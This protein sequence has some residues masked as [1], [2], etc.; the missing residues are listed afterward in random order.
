MNQHLLNCIGVGHSRL[1]EICRL[2]ETFGFA[3]KLTGAGGGGCAIILLDPDASD[4]AIK[5]LETE[6]NDDA[7]FRCWK[8]VMG[9]EGV[10]VTYF[11]SDYFSQFSLETG[12]FS[13]TFFK[14]L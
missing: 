11:N 14:S 7:K 8:T 4:D 2:A 12:N 5:Q 9:C 10:K 3:A 6:L 13:S 1:D